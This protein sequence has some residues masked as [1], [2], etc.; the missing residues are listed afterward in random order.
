MI[1]VAI[2][3]GFV[4]VMAIVIA[5]TNRGIKRQIAQANAK[6]HELPCTAVRDLTEGARVRVVGKAQPAGELVKAP[7]S[8]QM[9]LA[10]HAQ[11]SARVGDNEHG[12]TL[13]SPESQD[14]RA[15]R[16]QDATGSI[17][18][19]LAHVSL[20]LRRNLLSD[21]QLERHAFGARILAREAQDVRYYEYV[22][23]ASDDVAVI[24]RVRRGQDGSL[25]LVGEPGEPLVISNQSAALIT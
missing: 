23:V 7:Y 22:L 8:G 13:R 11:N 6:L 5:I 24:G 16:V 15:F 21:D 1:P 14:V 25:R 12:K 17:E 4:A 3:V 2:T 19:D 9:C 18:L 10:F 20:Q